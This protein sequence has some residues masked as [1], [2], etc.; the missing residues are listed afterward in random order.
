MGLLM[1]G[2]AGPIGVGVALATKRLERRDGKPKQALKDIVV[3]SR[4]AVTFTRRSALER[5][6]LDDEVA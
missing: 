1:I 5:E 4:E 6:P 2:S 3:T